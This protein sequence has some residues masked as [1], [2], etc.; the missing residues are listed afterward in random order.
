M[1][2][3]LPPQMPAVAPFA[4]TDGGYPHTNERR[5][6]GLFSGESGAFQAQFYPDRLVLIPTKR[7]AEQRE[8]LCR[9]GSVDKLHPGRLCGIISAGDV[10]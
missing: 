9:F 3:T 7:S 1:N 6:N 8:C 4:G 2:A 10:T 5:A